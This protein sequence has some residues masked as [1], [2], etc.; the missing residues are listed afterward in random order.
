[1]GLKGRV[2]KKIGCHGDQDKCLRPRGWFC[3]LP[4]ISC[5][6][7]AKMLKMHLYLGPQCVLAGMRMLAG[8]E[9]SLGMF[10]M[11]VFR[12]NCCGDVPGVASAPCSRFEAGKQEGT[13]GVC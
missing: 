8:G 9:A 6:V 7:L 2:C 4:Q 3:P 11:P 5:L 10:L 1:M 13:G 12:V